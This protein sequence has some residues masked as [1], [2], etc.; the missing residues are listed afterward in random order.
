MINIIE[1][2]NKESLT[3]ASINAIKESDIIISYNYDF[4]K[5]KDLINQESEIF[6]IEELK[7]DL[8]DLDST[9]IDSDSNNDL[10][11]DSNI[12]ACEFA[13]SKSFDNKKVSLISNEYLKFGF[14]SLIYQIASKYSEKTDIKIYPTVSAINYTSSIIGSP[15]DDFASI[16]FANP[17]IPLSEFK[18]K[19]ENA[20]KSNF[21]LAIYNPLYNIELF[22]RFKELIVETLGEDTL[23]ASVNLE[24]NSKSLIK[25]V[26][27]DDTFKSSFLIVAN[28]FTYQEDNLMITP[29]SYMIKND[30]VSYTEEFFEKYLNGE[31]PCGL[32]YDCDYLP[33]HKE[34]EACDYCYC[35]FYPCGESS[36]GGKWI[37]DKNVW[38]CQ[39]C[40]WIHK[41]SADKC[42]REKFDKIFTEV[43]DLNL[44]KEELLK[45]RREC[46]FKTK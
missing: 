34:L 18:L 7:G 33:C 16:N 8:D 46:L 21:I 45:I 15:L 36:T 43:E 41:E 42:I 9:S 40:I 23:I 10:F 31:S 37:K 5:I 32:D 38:D 1:F 2:I 27:L 17:L 3:L 12:K 22:N 11:N 19:I 30:I 44:K 28:K 6:F 20:L 26:D 25:V 35:P 29:R 14:N 4:E 24:D 13:L 39:D